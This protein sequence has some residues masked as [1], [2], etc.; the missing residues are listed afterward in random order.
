MN[1]SCAESDADSS[2]SGSFITP[3]TG[4]ESDGASLRLRHVSAVPVHIGDGHVDAW[5]IASLGDGTLD[6]II[7]VP[8]QEAPSR[9]VSIEMPSALMCPITMALLVDPVITAD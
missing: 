3:R 1:V 7:T 2:C 8:R 6:T 4:G 9:S 5:A